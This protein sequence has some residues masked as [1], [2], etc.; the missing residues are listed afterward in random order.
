MT[1]T[2]T[3]DPDAPGGSS[4]IGSTGVW[5]RTDA[6]AARETARAV[7]GAARGA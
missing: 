5:I 4:A 3:S 7:E 6:M 2:K 1:D